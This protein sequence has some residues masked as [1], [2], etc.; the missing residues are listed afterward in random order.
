MYEVSRKVT[1]FRKGTMYFGN[2][3]SASET[4]EVFR[5]RTKY[6]GNVRSIPERYEVSRK[7]TKYSGNV[8]SIPERYIWFP[9][10]ITMTGS[11][12][13]KTPDPY[14]GFSQFWRVSSNLL[15]KLDE[16][17][18][19]SGFSITRTKSIRFYRLIIPRDYSTWS[20]H[21]IPRSN[22]NTWS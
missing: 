6:L 2:A 3:Q 22:H 9:T 18:F 4:H 8:R 19:L 13:V 5:I 12:E 10:W 15:T 11:N 1:V 17:S 7:G 14:Y 21:V 20:H 16:S